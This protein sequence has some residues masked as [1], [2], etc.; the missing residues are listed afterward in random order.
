[1]QLCRTWNGY[2]PRLLGQQPSKRDLSWCCLLPFCNTAKQIDQ[3]LIRLECLWCEARQGAA[4]V[5][6]VKGRVFVDLARE[7]A[8]AQRAV[9]DKSDAKFLKGRYHFRF[10]L[11][12]PQRVFALKSRDWHN[13]MGATD[14]LHSC[15]R[16]SKVLHFTFLN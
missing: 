14:R 8:F 4:K 13:G 5:G 12:P 2:D 11:S 15:F 16:E 1:M 6:A 3:G 7:E 10:R 9:R